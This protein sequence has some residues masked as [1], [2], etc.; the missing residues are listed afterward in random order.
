MVSEHYNRADLA[1]SILAALG[2]SGKAMPSLA[3]EDLAPV[4]QFHIGGKESTL[5]LAHR[6]G[7]AAGQA[8]EVQMLDIGGGLG[9]PARLLARDLGCKAVVLDITEEYCRAGEMLTRHAGLGERVSFWHGDAL[10]LPFAGESFDLVWTQH[11]SMNIGDKERLYAEIRRVLR[12]GGR[13]ALH[14]VMAGPA[15][16]SIHFPVPWARDP[17]ISHLRRPADVRAILER[18]GFNALTWEDETALAIEWYQQRL[19]ATQSGSSS[20]APLGLH[21]LLGDDA[22]EMFRNVL[23]NLKEDRV[24]VV[25]GVF[26]AA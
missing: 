22:D 16:G 10:D 2:A 21:L 26:A 15:I 5:R 3:L 20:P 7:L 11:S 18:L 14:E 1:A 8:V 24:V 4:D 17:A 12:P 9:G 23:R 6:A 25:Q 19:A 13:L